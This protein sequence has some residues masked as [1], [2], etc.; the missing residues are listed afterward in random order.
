MNQVQRLRKTSGSYRSK[1]ISYYQPFGLT[2]GALVS[3]AMIQK[4]G[5]VPINE[6][7][8]NPL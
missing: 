7:E 1:Y 6:G 3:H 8:V 5:P 2:Q 4:R